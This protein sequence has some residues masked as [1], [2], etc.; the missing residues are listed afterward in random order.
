M[1]PE[2]RQAEAEYYLTKTVTY[3]VNNCQRTV[4]KERK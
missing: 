4:A 3:R 2:R 1:Q